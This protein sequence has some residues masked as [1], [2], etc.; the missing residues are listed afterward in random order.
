MRFSWAA[1]SSGPAEI[2]LGEE[3]ALH[4]LFV[5]TG[6][7][8]RSPL[9]ER[10][11]AA[12][13]AHAQ[14]A[15]LTSSSAGTRALIGRPMHAEAAMVLAG[16]GGDASEFVAR[17]INAKIAT[18]ADLV[19]TMTQAHR[20]RVLE[21]APRRL[22]MTF[23]LSEASRLAAEFGAQ[24]VADL[25]ALRPRLDTSERPD[26]TDPMGKSAA[27]FAAVGSQIAELL[28]PIIDLF[29]GG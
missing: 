8:C 23:T 27:T 26:I 7:I 4:V 9:A 3:F 22:N 17:Q 29:R 15:D 2:S 12:Y 24:T 16:L 28:P 6:N 18:R 21:L 10:F 1:A 19:L 13:V 20:D 5:C 25:A 14:V 11:T